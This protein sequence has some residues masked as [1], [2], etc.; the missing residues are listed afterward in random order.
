GVFTVADLDKDNV[1]GIPC[2]FGLTQKNGQ[3]QVEPAHPVLARGKVRHV[4]DPVALVVAETL[5]QARDA[6]EAIA[7]DHEELPAVVSTEK[8]AQATGAP[9]H[10]EAP[11][12]VCFEWEIG[13]KA[14]TDEG[15]AKA[16]HVTKLEFVNNRLVPNAMEPRCA[17]GEY[18]RATDSYT[19]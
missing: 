7:V 13:D 17:V 12:N 15:F 19:L 3:P 1:G 18:E 16:H 11:N 2:G 8:A 9:V 14:K 10:D 5:A 6:A 4:G